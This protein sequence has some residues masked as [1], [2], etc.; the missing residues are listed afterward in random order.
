[1]NLDRQNGN[2]CKIDSKNQRQNINER[3]NHKV[4]FDRKRNQ[5]LIFEGPRHCLSNND[6]VM[7]Y[8]SI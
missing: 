5:I 2:I 6:N 7:A 3:T 1:M 4:S 8:I